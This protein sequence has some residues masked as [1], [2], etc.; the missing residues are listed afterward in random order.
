MLT[1]LRYAPLKRQ[2]NEWCQITIQSVS[3][4]FDLVNKF[5]NRLTIKLQLVQARNKQL[6]PLKSLYVNSNDIKISLPDAVIINASRNG[7]SK[8]KINIDLNF[9]VDRLYDSES[10]RFHFV[11]MYVFQIAPCHPLLRDYIMRDEASKWE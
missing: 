6:D 10:E 11:I 8:V 5:N 4:P 9:N 3:L 2:K 1:E 7:E